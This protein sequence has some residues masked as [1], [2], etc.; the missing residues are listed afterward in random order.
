LVDGIEVRLEDPE[1]APRYMI[2]VIVA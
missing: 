1:G 2:G